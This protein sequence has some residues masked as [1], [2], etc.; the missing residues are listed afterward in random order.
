MPH[1]TEHHAHPQ[2]GVAIAGGGT[3]ITTILAEGWPDWVIGLL[4]TVF[5]VVGF[6]IMI[7]GLQRYHQMAQ[8]LAVEEEV[9]AIPTRLIVVLTVLLQA[10]TVTVLILFLLR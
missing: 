3:A 9:E 5:I 7:V 1:S 8:R 4:A 6:T 2:L 10:A